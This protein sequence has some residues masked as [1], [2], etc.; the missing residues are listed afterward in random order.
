MPRHA[1]PG[2]AHLRHDLVEVVTVF[3][4]AHATVDLEPLRRQSGNVGQPC[5]SRQVGARGVDPQAR[6]DEI[7]A[8]I[9]ATLRFQRHV[10]DRRP[11]TLE[12]VARLAYAHP[13]RD[14]VRVCGEI[15]G[16]AR[17]PRDSRQVRPGGADPQIGPHELARQADRSLG[18]QP[19]LAQAGLDGIED[20]GRSAVADM[21]LH[22][23]RFGGKRDAGDLVER[24][25]GR[26][27]SGDLQIGAVELRR[28][29]DDPLELHGR[30]AEHRFQRL[31]GDSAL[32]PL[33]LAF[34]LEPLGRQGPPGQRPE[35]RKV[36]SRSLEGEVGTDHPRRLSEN[37][38]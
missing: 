14:R 16:E 21:P 23:E 30:L 34:H 4:D 13:A 26:T 36:G 11:H 1:H 22:P 3:H 18:A 25:Q 6:S 5:D 35:H 29:T 28:F 15:R 37:A 9:H 38:L 33:Q 2:I 10:A 31:H 8:G 17:Q 19:V 12:L 24:G 32:Q 7:R 27:P 20:D